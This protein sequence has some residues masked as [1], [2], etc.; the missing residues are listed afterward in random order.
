MPATTGTEM[1]VGLM[2]GQYM[3]L[4][5]TLANLS[6]GDGISHR[7]RPRTTWGTRQGLSYDSLPFP[8]AAGGW[9]EWDDEAPWDVA[10]AQEEELWDVLS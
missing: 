9:E 1:W 10:G 3:A 4:Q 5:Q 6:T 7:R 8:S 2:M